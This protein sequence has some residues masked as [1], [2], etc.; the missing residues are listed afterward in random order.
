MQEAERYIERS[1]YVTALEKL[2][3]LKTRF[4]EKRIA[5]RAFLRIGEVYM[6]QKSY[7]ES[8]ALYESFLDLYPRD[9]EAG[10]ALFNIGLSY[11]K[12]LPRNAQN[13]L[14]EATKSLRAFRDFLHQYPQDPR[15]PEARNQM[16]QLRARLASK[17]WSIANFYLGW[18]EPSA[19]KQ[20]LEKII[21]D[22]PDSDFTS[23]ATLTLDRLQKEPHE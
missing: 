3:A 4:P 7:L 2:R 19:A 9:V 10:T 17:E 12:H 21:R 23:K 20:R 15:A 1:E 18:D 13:D 5:I 16:T 6:L 22:Y 8:A 11:S 14:S